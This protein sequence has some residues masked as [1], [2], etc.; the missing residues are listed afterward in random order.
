MNKERR[1]NELKK[2]FGLILG[3]VLIFSISP[4]QTSA[5]ETTGNDYPLVFVHGLGGWGP[6]EMLGVNYWGGFFDLDQYMDGKGYNMIPATVSPFSSNWDRAAELYAF[7]KGG[8]VDYG[9][10]HAKEHG[11][12]RYGK[13]YEKGAYPNL[14]E[15]NKIHLIGHSMGGNTIRTM[16]DLL[17]DGSASEMAYHQDHPEEGISPL[18]TG[19]KDWIHSV[20]TLGTPNSGTTY[21]DEENQMT[22]LL[23]SLVIHLATLSGKITNPD[24]IVYDLKF[25]QWGIKRNPGEGFRSYLNRV[26]DSNIWES[27]DISLF[28][29]TTRGAQQNN[30]WIDTHEEVYYFSHSSQTTY[31]SLL[32]G[33]HLP[34]ALTIPIFYQPSIY[35][36]K[37]TR[38]AAPAITK[39]WL[40][41]DGIVNT[42]SSLYPIGHK[43]QAYNG[44]TPPKKGVWNY[45]P[46]MMN[47]DHM[48]YMGINPV[49]YGTS[50]DIRNFY[51]KLANSLK[52]LPK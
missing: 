22:E 11:H 43:Y 40:P 25:E 34:N 49:S 30:T 33:H 28:D 39:D 1:L 44:V 36:G 6:G 2:L 26:M 41:N 3:L 14:D 35:I 42:I 8:T 48:D 29:L 23:K 24:L 9:A 12:S 13:T 31:R 18:F 38:K 20:T 16:T 45:Y 52:S 10:A 5:K 7:L 51:T 15:T 32:T 50:Y 17:I 21:A 47:Y 19:G 27:Q 4:I 46:T 37:Y